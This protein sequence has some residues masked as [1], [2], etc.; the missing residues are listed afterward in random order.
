M[1][2]SVA[3]ASQ[4]LEITLPAAG[5]DDAMPYNV[6]PPAQK[7]LNCGYTVEEWRHEECRGLGE[8]FTRQRPRI[9]GLDGR[10]CRRSPSGQ[11]RGSNLAGRAHMSHHQP[12]VLNSCD[13]Q[14]REASWWALCWG[15]LDGMQEVRGSNPFSSTSRNASPSPPLRAGCQ[16]S[17]SRSRVVTA[18]AP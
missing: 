12:T 17:V 10:P 7:S 6:S 13:S 15:S 4:W 2:L 16:Q 3:G 18:G 11:Q 8:V 5:P 9:D 14:P 1:C